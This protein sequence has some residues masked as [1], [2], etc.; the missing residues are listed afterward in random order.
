MAEGFKNAGFVYI[1]NHGIPQTTVAKVFSE[2]ASFFARPKSEK[3]QLAWTSAQ[4]N[5][6]YVAQGREKTSSLTDAKAIAALAANNPDLKETF[7]IGKEGVEG[8]PNNFPDRFDDQGV[9]FTKTMKE[10]FLTC[11][12]LHVK[13]MRSIALGMGLE[14]TFFDRYTDGGDNNLRL[15]HYPSAKKEVFVKNKGQVRAGCHTV[16]VIYH[17]AYV[18]PSTGK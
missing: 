11:K 8:F 5:R 6:G 2:S 15:L 3:E 9:E 10:F 18:F 13:V 16:C 7:E 4:S 17:F 12:D 1:K 14:E